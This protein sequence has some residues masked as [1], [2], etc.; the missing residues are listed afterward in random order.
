MASL[1]TVTIPD[2]VHDNVVPESSASVKSPFDPGVCR[3][4]FIRTKALLV[5]TPEIAVPLLCVK[6]NSFVNP[7]NPWVKSSNR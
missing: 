6:L 2:P 1:V 5:A 3:T 4:P 7:L